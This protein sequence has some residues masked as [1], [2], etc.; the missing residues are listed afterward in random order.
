M[1]LPIRRLYK[2]YCTRTWNATASSSN[3]QL[4]TLPFS[5]S[6]YIRSLHSRHF[7]VTYAV[8]KQQKQIQC[9]WGQ[10]LISTLV[11]CFLIT[12]P[13]SP[14]LRA[15]PIPNINLN[16]YF[17]KF[18]ISTSLYSFRNYWEPKVAFVYELYLLTITILE[19]KTEKYC[20]YVFI[21]K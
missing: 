9:K 2:S 18:R 17:S 12:N 19:I 7:E 20:I 13:E 16:Q 11:N 4:P 21:F 3:S 8:L 1:I 10:Q 5:G 6:A 14:G 15:G